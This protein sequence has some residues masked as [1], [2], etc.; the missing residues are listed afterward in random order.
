MKKTNN[1]ITI[2]FMSIILSAVS[3]FGAA[4]QSVQ[5]FTSNNADGKITAKSI[6]EA[7][8]KSGLIIDGNNDMN[9][10]FKLRFKNTYYKT[11]NLAMFRNKEVT[12]KLLK[13]YPTFGLLTPLTM[14]IW[15]DKGTMNISTLTLA[16]IAR[17]G[18]IPIDDPD[19]VAYSKSIEK[20]LRA[21][22]PKGHF[23]K[24]NH[25][26]QFPKKSFQTR[27]TMELEIDADTDIEELK[28]D[29]EAEFEG[30]MEPIG[31]LMPGYL[32]LV[33]EAFEPNG[34]DA[35]DFYDTYSVCKFDVIYPVSKLHPE[36]GAYA[37]C[38]FYLYKKKGENKMHMGWLGVDNWITTLDIKDEE[39][40]KPLRAAHKMIED[41]IKEIIE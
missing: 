38:A 4:A 19:L 41:I 22:M 8:G 3:A 2:V 20:A 12:L 25:I 6:D 36:A 5:V 31:F 40:I 26:V 29:F 21:A 7:F 24:L 10:P 17:A 30:E 15:S 37:P 13:K 28:E 16:G 14:S 18:E 34:Y 32:N 27:Y 35:Y 1:L 39:S 9:K 23:K 11:Y 33:D